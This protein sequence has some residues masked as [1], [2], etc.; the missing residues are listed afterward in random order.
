MLD[1]DGH[2]I[3][4]AHMARAS[5]RIAAK[6]AA[7]EIIRDIRRKPARQSFQTREQREH[8]TIN[9]AQQGIKR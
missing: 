3:L 2:S 7:G 1:E 4:A 5:E 6:K 9:H 8:G